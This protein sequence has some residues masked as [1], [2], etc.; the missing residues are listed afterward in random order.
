M[1]GQQILDGFKPSKEKK[2]SKATKTPLISSQAGYEG[3]LSIDAFAKEEYSIAQAFKRIEESL[4]DDMFI[5]ID[6]E[7]P[8]SIDEWRVHQLKRLEQYRKNNIKEY[9]PIF[10]E[11]NER[12]VQIIRGKFYAGLNAEEKRI[13]KAI[14]NGY[15]PGVSAEMSKMVFNINEQKLNALIKA[16]MSDM[17][18]AEQAVLRRAEDSYRKIIFDAEVAVNT[19]SMSYKEAVDMATKD[20]LAAGI[21][22]V[23]YKNGAKHKISDYCDMALKTADKKAYLYGEGEKRREHGCHLVI[24]NKR[25]DETCECCAPYVG[26]ILVDD[27]YS[28]GTKEEARR[29]GYTLLSKAMA[30]G[31]YHPR[32]K[33]IHTTYFPG[34][35]P[36]PSNLTRKE[37]EKIKEKAKAKNHESYVNRQQEKYE[38]MSKYSMATENKKQYKSKQKEWKN[39][40]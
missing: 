1:E 19:G 3:Q 13:M 18:K 8:S 9:T 16:T 24:V 25:G 40:K 22:C 26:K 31:L 38:R 20:F 11:L 23:T 4:I 39:A 17:K 14:K 15:D 28:G 7:A 29:L 35:T 33:D 6:K 21:Q 10:D 27:V 36:L 34:I 2:P 32:C 30:E 12:M 5:R 37:K